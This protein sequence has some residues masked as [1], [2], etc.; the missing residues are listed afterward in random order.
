MALSILDDPAE[1]ASSVQDAML[2]ALKSLHAYRCQAK[3]TT[4]LYSITLNVCRGRLRKRRI[5]ERL[6]QTLDRAFGID[7]AENDQPE[8]RAIRNESDAEVW[9]AIQSLP[10]KLRL[11]VTLRYY[12]ALPIGEIAQVLEIS[13]RAVH[14]R[15]QAAHERLRV[16]LD[17]R[18][19]ER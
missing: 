19:A 15:L 12:H 7:R 8:V 10:E 16:T 17:R 14:H 3:L 5:R 13:E 6:R 9:R 2:R 18:V 11:A 1:A 4:W